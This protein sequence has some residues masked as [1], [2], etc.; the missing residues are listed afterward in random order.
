[1]EYNNF[2]SITSGDTKYTFGYMWYKESTSNNE[3]HL[4]LGTSGKGS[5]IH[6][7]YN[8]KERTAFKSN[9]GYF[10]ECDIDKSLKRGAGGTY[11]MIFSAMYLLIKKY[12]ECKLIDWVDNS[13]ITLRINKKEYDVSL[14][15]SDTILNG[16]PRIQTIISKEAIVFKEYNTI[17]KNINRLSTYNNYTFDEFYDNFYKSKGLFTDTEKKRLKSIYLDNSLLDF[18]K[19]ADEYLK[20][21][22]KVKYIFVPLQDIFYDLGIFSF[23]GKNWIVDIHKAFNNIK[24]KYNVKFSRYTIQ[25]AGGISRKVKN[26]IEKLPYTYTCNEFYNVNNKWYH[27]KIY[28]NIIETL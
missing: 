21:V 18:F 8:I 12:P 20:T 7:V 3:R 5:C 28:R 24:N 26:V 10:K 13:I 17:I 23:I 9:I 22:V 11:L 14:S 6:I 1:M 16:Y 25:S 2:V 19:S 4:Y 27:L 15:N